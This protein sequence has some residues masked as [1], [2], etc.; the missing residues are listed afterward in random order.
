MFDELDQASRSCNVEIQSIPERKG[1]N[2]IQL[3]LEISKIL[4]VELN[5]SDI[6]NVHRVA[7]GLPTTR[8]KNIILQ[9]TTRR[10]RDDLIVATVLHC[11]EQRQYSNQDRNDKS[12]SKQL[13]RELLNP[14]EGFNTYYSPPVNKQVSEEEASKNKNKHQGRIFISPKPSAPVDLRKGKPKMPPKQ[15]LA[16]NKP[17]K[18]QK[19]SKAKNPNNGNES[20]Q[21]NVDVNI[22]VDENTNECVCVCPKPR[23]R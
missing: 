22:G 8:P 3:S 14:P 10:Q 7:P 23:L 13:I 11:T 15:N 17:P 19:P 18:K 21:V 5:H 2:L 16:K 9:L 12:L 1:E 6:R 4:G 20:Q